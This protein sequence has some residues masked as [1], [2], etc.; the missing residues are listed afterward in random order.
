M[1]VLVVYVIVDSASG[2]RQKKDVFIGVNMS[3][4]HTDKFAV[5]FY[6]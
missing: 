1:L 5:N 4:P 3:K 2:Y 6:A